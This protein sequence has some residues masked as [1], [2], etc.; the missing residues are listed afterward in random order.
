MLGEAL[1]LGN[2]GFTIKKWDGMGLCEQQ[3]ICKEGFKDI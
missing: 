1:S 2:H 3:L